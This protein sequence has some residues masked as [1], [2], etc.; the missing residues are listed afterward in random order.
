MLGEIAQDIRYGVRKLL[1]RPG[2]TAVVIGVLALGIGATTAL[3]SAVDA[4][5]LRPLPFDEAERLVVVEGIGI[6]FSSD[7]KTLLHDKTLPSISDA[8]ELPNTFEG[9]AA[10]APGGLNLTGGSEPLRVRV[11]LATP[12]FFPTLG[13]QPVMGRAFIEDEGTASGARVA[14][15]SDGL[16]RRQFGADPAIIG[17]TV[18]LNGVSHEVVGVMPRSFAFPSRTELWLPLPVPM[19]FDRLEPFGSY[20]PSGIIARLAPGVTLEQAAARFQALQRVYERDADRADRTA[21]APLQPLQSNLVGKGRNALLVLL[22]AT[23][24]VLIIACANVTNL[25]LAR[26]AERR[27]EVALRAALGASRGRIVRQFLTESLM[28]SVA[29]AVAGILVALLSLRGLTALMP[30]QLV[31]VAPPRLDLRVLGYALGVAALTGLIFGL[32]PALGAAR[33]DAGEMI[34]SAAGT[35]ATARSGARIRRVLVVSEIAIALML[36]VGTGLMLRSFRALMN[37][38]PGVRPERVATMELKLARASY[39][40]VTEIGVFHQMLL[41]RLNATPG[42]EAA[43]VVSH[44][45]LGGTNQIRLTYEVEGRPRD[46]NAEM[47]FAEFL[48]ASPDYFRAMGITLLRGRGITVQDDSLNPVV[49]IN[50]AMAEQVWPGEAPI[51][52]RIIIGDRHARTVVGVVADVRTRSL[53]VPPWP[54]VYLP[55]AEMPPVNAGVV[56]RGTLPSTALMAAM[57][58]AVRAVDPE[59]AVYN[60]RM[61][62]EVISSAIAPRRINTLLITIFGALALTLAAL[63]VYAVI[64]YGV[65]QRTR[66]LGIRIALGAQRRDVISLITREGIWLALAGIVLGLAGAFALTRVMASLVYGVEVTDPVAFALAPVVLL[67][68]ALGA[69]LLPARRATRVNPLE[70]IRSD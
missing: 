58:D 15:L 14:I 44:L 3:F 28:L 61:L 37:T 23:G 55:L 9:V 1:Q 63:G 20:L 12:S 31:D 46:P 36:L 10:Y 11:T 68:I 41:D 62:E 39:A 65:T 47:T 29:G 48:R 33:A 2:F 42:I 54:Q 27:R 69:A 13:A 53:D 35:G 17:K 49:V 38:D 22:G 8:A 32:W 25:L 7:G 40:K 60:V 50:R 45:P 18:A 5:L 24:L 64:A 19:T 57:R 21:G 66:E 6:G 51:G 30:A 4:A 43:A 59:Q 56:A 16:W 52:Q 70:A 67:V 34:K 26:A